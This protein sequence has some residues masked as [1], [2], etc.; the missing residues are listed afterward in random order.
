MKSMKINEAF[1]IVFVTVLCM[2]CGGIPDTKKGD[3]HLR[4][5]IPYMNSFLVVPENEDK[6]IN[7]G[8]WGIGIGLDYYHSDNQFLNLEASGAIDFFLPIPAAVDPSFEDGAEDRSL[9]SVHFTLSNNHKVK[10]FSFG[11]GIAYAIYFS[12]YSYY[13]YSETSELPPTYHLNTNHGAFGLIFPNY[14]FFTKNIGV[15]VVYRPTFFRPTLS[16]KF[17]YEHLISVEF[18]TKIPFYSADK[19]RFF[20]WN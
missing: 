8:F 16:D 10:K 2:S 18:A 19:R 13:N 6:K 17:K 7:T 15:G 11:Y 12:N 9:G 4:P 5:S 20:K 3:M 14:F 1:V